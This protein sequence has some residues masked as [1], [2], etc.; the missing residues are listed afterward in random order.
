MSVLKIGAKGLP[1]EWYGLPAEWYGLPA[2]WYG[3]PAEWYGLPAE[4][5]I[6]LCISVFSLPIFA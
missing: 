2:E 4:W 3:L 1:A 5:L 6:L